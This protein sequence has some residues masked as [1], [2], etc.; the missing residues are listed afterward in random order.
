MAALG[1]LGRGNGWENQLLP[2]R[3]AALGEKVAAVS[4]EKEHSL[5]LTVS[6]AVWSWGC[7]S[8]G[9][10]GHG[11]EKTQQRPLRILAMG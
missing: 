5:A 3:I 7:G 2:G 8:Y 4:T 6:G 11:D 9:Q 10:L 1:R